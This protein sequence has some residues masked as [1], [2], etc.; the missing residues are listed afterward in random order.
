MILRGVDYGAVSGAAGVQGWFGEGYR[1]HKCWG[2]FAPRFAGMTFV[3]KTTTLHAREGNM[4]LRSREW[5][6]KALI[7]PCVKVYPWRRM[8]VNAVGLSGPGAAALLAAGQWQQRDEPFMLS[9]MSVAPDAE[10]RLA[11]LR[12]YL[13]LLKRYTFR[14]PFALQINFSCPNVGLDPSALTDEILRALDAVEEKALDAAVIPK[15]NA[16]FPTS[17]ALRISRHA[18]C[19]AICVSNTL[20]WSK[21]Y[22]DTPSPLAHLGGGGVSGAPLLEHVIEW[23]S[24]ARRARL[25][26]PLNVGG[27]I[28]CTDDINQLVL[29]GVAPGFDSFFLGS[30]AILRP[31]RTQA[32]VRHVH[33][34]SR[35]AEAVLG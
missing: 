21:L 28:L 20:P 24:Q 16:A 33:E 27:G 31:W 17:T 4:P 29:A 25:D 11:E 14:V 1:V 32:V 23:V 22:P 15:I 2:P 30:I 35:E 26:I 3:A 34:L 8:V 9:F 19:D 5:Q 13:S 18:R 12:L 7:P 10:A 6:P